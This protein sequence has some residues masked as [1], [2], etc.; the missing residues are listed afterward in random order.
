MHCV[1]GVNWGN[2]YILGSALLHDEL[3][4]TISLGGVLRVREGN[5]RKPVYVELLSFSP[6]TWAYPYP[7]GSGVCASPTLGGK[8]I[9][10]FGGN[11]K[12]LVIKPGRTPEVVAVNRIER[13]LPGRMNHWDPFPKDR[14]NDWYPECTVSSPIFDG[15]RIYYR[16]ERHLYCIGE[17]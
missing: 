13:M 15:K 8:N 12:T 3:M 11:G 1:P 10:L 4:Y 16:A 2:T 7:N 5:A 9:Y 17:K 6:I 14:K